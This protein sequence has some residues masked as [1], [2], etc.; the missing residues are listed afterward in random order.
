MKNYHLLTTFSSQ[1]FSVFKFY[2]STVSS[3]R[4]H[5]PQQ[6]IMKEQTTKAASA[7]EHH[8]DKKREEKTLNLLGPHEP[9]T[10]NN[11]SEA[12]CFF[13]KLWTLV[14]CYIW[15]QIGSQ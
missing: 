5:Q 13:K 15:L 2:D 14:L 12:E 3:S 1:D 11:G 8:D 4:P 9:R 7:T 6:H 10:F